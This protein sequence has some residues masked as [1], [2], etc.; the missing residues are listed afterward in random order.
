MVCAGH[1]ALEIS[2]GHRSTGPKNS[3]CGHLSMPASTGKG[4]SQICQVQ[5]AALTS[6]EADGTFPERLAYLQ[7]WHGMA[8]VIWIKPREQNTKICNQK[9]IRIG[10]YLINQF[11]PQDLGFFPG[12]SS[13]QRLPP[14][15]QR[16]FW[17]H[18]LTTQDIKQPIIS[19][20]NLGLGISTYLEAKNV[21]FV[22]VTKQWGLF[23][24]NSQ[25]SGQKL[26]S[27]GYVLI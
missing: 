10:Y 26:Y 3:P 22:E 16:T 27:L 1:F 12:V 15:A 11:N 23:F 14:A 9:T 5:W 18:G 17:F 19:M 13:L 24:N 2:T 21:E 7:E 6:Q 20:R 25:N 8:S 4:P